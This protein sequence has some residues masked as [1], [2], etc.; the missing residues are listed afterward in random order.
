MDKNNTKLEKTDL[1]EI[2]EKT[3]N[4]MENSSLKAFRVQ[5]TSTKIRVQE[6]STRIIVQE[7]STR[8]SR[9]KEASSVQEPETS[10]TTNLAEKKEMRNF[11]SSKVELKNY[12]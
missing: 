3:L 12:R 6:T 2:E 5:E 11:N 7:T 4:T 1:N 9:N 8:K 10:T